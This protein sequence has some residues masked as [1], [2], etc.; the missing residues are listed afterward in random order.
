M[1]LFACSQLLTKNR[2][3]IH[4]TMALDCFCVAYLFFYFWSA[5]SHIVLPAALW[6]SDIS[7]LFMISLTFY[8]AS[9]AILRSGGKALRRSVPLLIPLALFIIGFGT[10][11]AI[12]RPSVAGVPDDSP[13]HFS[14]P[15][16]SWL[17]TASFLCL[18]VSMILCLVVAYRVNASGHVVHRKLFRSQVIFL[19][20]YLACALSALYGCLARDREILKLAIVSS[21]SI[22]IV[23]TLTAST[24]LYFPADRPD[25]IRTSP[26]R[27]EWD[28]NSESLSKRLDLLMERT[29]PYRDANLSLGK[30]ARMLGEDPRRL[31]YHFKISLS[32]NFRGYLNGLRLKAVCRDLVEMPNSTILTIA[33]ENGF[34]S[35]SNFN[36][37]FYKTFAV[38]P[39]DFRARETGRAQ[40]VVEAR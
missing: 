18:A 37:L 8:L 10:Y 32:T 9:T 4:Q 26:T 24:I 28:L 20:L 34:N 27:P 12:A 17:S 15:L 31:S 25:R 2:T 16:L 39:R 30:L 19:A 33:F 6:S 1:F 7:F 21:G 3:P 35:K 23:F 11:N 14:S 22:A 13:G 36:A 29:A 40:G 5:E 38:T